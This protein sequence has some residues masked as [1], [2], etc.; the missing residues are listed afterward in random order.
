MK[1][2]DK[3]LKVADEQLVKQKIV[4]NS[5]TIENTKAAAIAGFGAMVINIGLASTLAVYKDKN[6]D[7]YEALCGII[8]KNFDDTISPNI[9]LANKRI[10]TKQFVDA[11]V[12]L[13]IM[14]RTYKINKNDD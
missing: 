11:S 3:L 9:S 10:L 13:K 2:I 12:A 4:Q 8:R 14:A 5:A 7:V 1:A 6:N